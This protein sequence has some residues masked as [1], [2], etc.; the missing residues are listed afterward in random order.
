MKTY[1]AELIENGK[2]VNS[3]EE[4]TTEDWSIW[5]F[6]KALNHLKP[7]CGEIR[8]YVDGQLRLS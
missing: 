8:W 4:T 7:R 6:T 2:V 5:R 3:Y 1:K